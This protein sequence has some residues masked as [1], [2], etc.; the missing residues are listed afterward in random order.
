MNTFGE[1][2]R[3]LREAQNILLRQVAAHLEVDT[4]F[5]SKLERGE[6]KASREQACKL[7]EI[8]SVPEQELLP[9]WLSD[10]LMEILNYDS[11]SEAA[12]KLTQR[13]IKNST[14]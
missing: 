2:V 14:K 9:L 12:M 4:A 3:S 11:Y 10:R 1:K 7:A 13:R 6:K 5:L 8:L